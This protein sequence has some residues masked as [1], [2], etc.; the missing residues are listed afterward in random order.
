M[1]L[2]V[3]L[4]PQLEAFIHNTVTSGRYQSASEVVRTALRLL[5]EREQERAMK[6]ERLRQDIHKG[7]ESGPATP[8]DMDEIKRQGRASGQRHKLAFMS[9]VYKLPQA[10]DDL[11]DIWGHIASDSPFHAD[12]FLDLLSDKMRLLADAPGI[13]SSRAELSPG[14]RSLPVGNYVLFYRE[15]GRGIEVVRV[16]HGSRDIEAVFHDAE[17]GTDTR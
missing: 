9:R 2:N 15:A 17:T 3:S 16:L 11:L 4:T 10:E 14:L 12:R 5:E 13:G 6:I 7:L 8:L 1:T